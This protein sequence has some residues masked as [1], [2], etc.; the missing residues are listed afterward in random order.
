MARDGDD[1]RTEAAADAAGRHPPTA[2]AAQ[3][4]AWRQLGAAKFQDAAYQRYAQGF[5]SS[6]SLSAAGRAGFAETARRHGRDFAADL[7]ARHRQDHPTDA[8]RA[9]I[10]LLGELGQAEG[11]DYVRE[12]R[13]AGG[14]YADF[15][16]PERRLAL[17]VHGSAHRAQYFLERG[18]H[19][20]EDRKA[21]L[22]DAAGWEVRVVTDRELFERGAE[23]RERVRAILR[24]APAAQRP[25]WGRAGGGEEERACARRGNR[26]SS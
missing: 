17:E 8:E 14:C 3:R 24:P 23:T 18:M 6:E 12:H 10:A 19:E 5:R 4:E 11:A 7:L 22:Y 2:T 25:L 1:A 13:V 16:W 20:R 21:A 26:W 9:M 15:A